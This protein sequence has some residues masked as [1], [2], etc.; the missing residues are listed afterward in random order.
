MI[1]AVSSIGACATNG[2]PVFSSDHSPSTAS[3]F[4]AR[5]R[6]VYSTPTVRLGIV[7]VTASPFAEYMVISLAIA[8]N[9]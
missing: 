2:V 7:S 6:A 9:D 4:A 3:V 8:Q 1:T 5:I